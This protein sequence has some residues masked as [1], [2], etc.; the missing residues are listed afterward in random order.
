M[1]SVQFGSSIFCGSWA[2]RPARSCRGMATEDETGHIIKNEALSF[3]HRQTEAG[4]PT[5]G[6]GRRSETIWTSF[7]RLLS[8]PARKLAPCSPL[9]L[10]KD[11]Q[12]TPKLL[13]DGNLA[14][15]NPE[16]LVQGISTD[17][18]DHGQLQYI[19]LAWGLKHRTLV[20]PIIA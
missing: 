10:S 6:D 19:S 2:K 17:D 12:T 3:V 11:C 7:C 16:M 1:T 14:A 15:K 5:Q 18:I 4:W 8:V 20:R 13:H 9:V